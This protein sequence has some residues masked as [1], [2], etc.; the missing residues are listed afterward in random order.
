M[1]WE[2]VEP[3]WY[4]IPQLLLCLAGIALTVRRFIRKRQG[5]TY[6]EYEWIPVII[7][8]VLHLATPF[9]GFIPFPLRIVLAVAIVLAVCYAL[10]PK[11]LKKDK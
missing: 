9:A 11:L 4:T 5:L 2:F 10:G 3:Y 6:R 1:L 8:Y 7:S